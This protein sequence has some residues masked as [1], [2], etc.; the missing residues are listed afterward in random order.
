MYY[1]QMAERLTGI[2]FP[3]VFGVPSELNGNPITIT[4]VNPVRLLPNEF[5]YQ[6]TTPL[7]FSAGAAYF[8]GKRALVSFDAEY[9]NYPGIRLAAVELGAFANQQFKDKYNGQVKANFQ[10]ALNLKVGA[11]IRVSSAWS[12]R[13]GVATYGQIYASDY[14]LI[15]RSQFQ[16]SAGLGYR[17]NAFYL[18]LGVWQ[19][20]GK[21]AYTPYV[22]KNAADYGSAA[23]QILNTQVVIGGGVYF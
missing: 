9:M 11:E 22:L 12:V 4:K 14:D 16:I 7:K 19:R 15:D 3:R 17:S 10:S 2:T 21:D 13:G 1:D 23:L 20:T 5:N 18:D 8:F 6:M